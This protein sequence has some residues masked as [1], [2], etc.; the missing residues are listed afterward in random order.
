MAANP[1]VQR[2]TPCGYFTRNVGGFLRNNG[3]TIGCIATDALI[4]GNPYSMIPAVVVTLGVSVIDHTFGEKIG[5]PIK[6]VAFLGGLYSKPA[7][8]VG[9]VL[10]SLGI[11][12]A[13]DCLGIKSRTVR[14]VSGYWAA[15]FGGSALESIKD[16]LSSF[17]AAGTASLSEI[18]LNT[19]PSLGYNA[20]D[21][22]CEESAS[23][24]FI[25]PG[26]RIIPELECQKAL[27][28]QAQLN[29]FVGS[30]A[31]ELLNFINQ[32]F[33]Y[34][35]LG[36]PASTPSEFWRIEKRNGTHIF[37]FTTKFDFMYVQKEASTPFMAIKDLLDKGAK[38]ECARARGLALHIIIFDLLGESFFNKYFAR[39]GSLNLALG[40]PHLRSIMP[41]DLWGDAESFQPGA[42]WHMTNHPEYR[43]L[44]A[45]FAGG[46]N[47]ISVGTN[48]AGAPVFMGFGDRFF[49]P[50][51][52]V[53]QALTIDELKDSLFEDFLTDP[54]FFYDGI[55]TDSSFWNALIN[56][57]T[58][59]DF[60]SSSERAL[61]HRITHNRT[62]WD[63]AQTEGQSAYGKPYVFMREAIETLRRG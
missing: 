53:E 16:S 40:L 39:S 24:H 59:L 14:Q 60:L 20:S 56:D 18:S 3:P 42:F 57:F 12:R 47:L 28:S 21:Y 17:P 55:L 23:E 51:P 8:T 36:Q 5:L 9:A 31:L 19:Y 11:S 37:D 35:N 34:N 58:F 1:D 25:V 48:N 33:S 38:F 63:I 49:G 29:K 26:L 45:G 4:T 32:K 44:I 41:K 46:E 2:E 10:S 6:M 50:K 52:I 43:S 27:T 15:R 61:V 62:A 22:A 7:A 54:L 30:R 13:A